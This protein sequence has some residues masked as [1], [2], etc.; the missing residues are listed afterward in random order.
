[1]GIL[2]GIADSPQTGYADIYTGK[3]LKFENWQPRGGVLSSMFESIISPD[4]NIYHVITHYA[5]ALSKA[6]WADY[7]F[8][9]LSHESGKWVRKDGGTSEQFWTV[10]VAEQNRMPNMMDWEVYE[11][12]DQPVFAA[13]LVTSAVIFFVGA[14]NWVVI[15]AYFRIVSLFTEFM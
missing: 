12:T 5:K 11:N 13:T 15:Q 1:M 3:S 10:C 2:L 14:V 7:S 6:F 8:A 9:V 4:S